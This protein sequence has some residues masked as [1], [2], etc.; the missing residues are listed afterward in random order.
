M[1]DK[2]SKTILIRNKRAEF[3]YYFL[4]KLTAGLVLTGTEIKSI[5]T[6]KASL[7]DTYCIITRHEV[8]VKGMY[9]APYFY[10]SFSNTGERRDRKLL[11]NRREI[12][13]LETEIKNPG[14]T[15]V[16]TKLF[17]DDKGRAKLEIA[18]ARGK[19][20]YDKREVLKEK[21]DRRE[22]DRAM[23]LYSK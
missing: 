3:D 22:M 18:L 16:P 11:L 7:V 20:Q 23:K 5:R 4:Q 15:I 17:I 19:K 21:N 8:W 9:V 1:N 14:L 2:I 6:G 12:S 13:K 10:G